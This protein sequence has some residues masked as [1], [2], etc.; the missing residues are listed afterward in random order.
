MEVGPHYG[1]FPKL[2]KS[3]AMLNECPPE[4]PCLA[5]LG[6]RFCMGHWYFGS[7]E[8]R[9][10]WNLWEALLSRFP[11]DLVR[12]SGLLLALAG[13]VL[14]FRRKEGHFMLWWLTGA[15]LYML[16]FLNLN[17]IHDYYQLPLVAPLAI[18]AVDHL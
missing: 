17:G 2:Q 8:R 13:I 1:Y 5:I 4:P 6:F 11:Q 14:A 16:V 9:L 18:A 7:V 15:T 10:D 12:T 3:I